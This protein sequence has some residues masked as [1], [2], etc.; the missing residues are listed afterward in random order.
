MLCDVCSKSIRTAS[1]M[2]F[3]RGWCKPAAVV[4]PVVAAV[5]YAKPVQRALNA[6]ELRHAAGLPFHGTPVAPAAPVSD[7]LVPD[8]TVSPMRRAIAAEERRLAE[9]E[10]TAVELSPSLR[11]SLAFAMGISNHAPRRAA[12]V[13]LPE[14]EPEPSKYS[15]PVAIPCA[16]ETPHA[17]HEHDADSYCPG[18]GPG[19]PVPVLPASWTARDVETYETPLRELA[20]VQ[21]PAGV[22][23]SMYEGPGPAWKRGNLKSEAAFCKMR[24]APFAGYLGLHDPLAISQTPLKGWTAPVGDPDATAEPE[25]VHAPA[26]VRVLPHERAQYRAKHHPRA[27]TPGSCWCPRHAAPVAGDGKAHSLPLILTPG[28]DYARNAAPLDDYAQ[29]A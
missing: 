17:R 5:P 26:Y 12:P 21:A 3:H 20:P 13:V 15:E 7:H 24:H 14:P 29:A 23:V 4:A 10:T 11:A 2:D 9:P 1:G 8:G 18:I 27:K 16:L 6:A 19:D 22:R 25:P 28:I